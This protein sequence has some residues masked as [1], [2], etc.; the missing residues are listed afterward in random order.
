MGIGDSLLIRIWGKIEEQFSAT[1]DNNGSIFIPK[2]GMVPVAGLPYSQVS[3]VIKREL[4]KN[5]VNFQVSV[6]LG[7]GRPNKIFVLGEVKFPGAFDLPVKSNL[8]SALYSAGGPTKSGSMRKIQLI[9]NR[10][11]IKTIDLYDY[12]MSADQSQDPTLQNFDT[13]FVPLIG[14][15][16]KVDGIVKRPAIFEIQ[17]GDTLYTA[18]QVMGGGTGINYYAKRVQVERIVEGQKRVIMDFSFSDA[19]QFKSGLKTEKLKN[20]DIIT[21][22]PIYSKR[23]NEINIQG[24]VTRPGVYELEQ[25][26]TLGELIKKADGFLK[27]AYLH[28]IDIYRQ[29]S[30]SEWS[31]I[32]V[33]Y[34]NNESAKLKLNEFD[35]ILVRSKQTVEG[36]KTVKVIGAVENSGQFLLLDGQRV[37][38]LAYMANVLPNADLSHAELARTNPDGSKNIININLEQIRQNPNSSENYILKNMDQLFIQENAKKTQTATVAINGQVRFPGTYVIRDGDRL[39]DIITRAGGLAPKGYLPGLVFKRQIV[40]KLQQDSKNYILNEEYRK[41]MLNPDRIKSLESPGYQ[42]LYTKILQERTITT[43]IENLGRL[44]LNITTLDQISPEYNIEINNGDSIFIPE[45]PTSVQISG[46]V[47][48][49]GAHVF[50]PGRNV[51]FYINA[52]GG[53]TTYAQPSQILI[54]RA[55]G[56]VLR[57]GGE[58]MQVAPGDTIYIPEEIKIPF[59]WVGGFFEFSKFLVNTLTSVVLVKSLL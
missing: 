55:S 47:Q 35:T 54:I 19:A 39:T 28:R 44:I 41:I 26:M 15:T 58:G 11:V 2:V 23:F 25:G 40:E 20:G 38:D 6:T 18:V 37:L 16:V 8:M 10:Q 33:D 45:I 27:D 17:D 49:A 59:D 1:V 29:K 31:I 13:I 24:N 57:E 9:R 21:V 34:T 50:I 36:V 56:E 48:N 52:C 14:N 3:N 22:F 46:G 7:S 53:Y 51:K 43:N 4:S 12:L 5:Y 32:A 30:E 42:N